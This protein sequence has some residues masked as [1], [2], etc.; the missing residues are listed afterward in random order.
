MI[1][2]LRVFV[3][4]TLGLV[5]AQYFNFL[6]INGILNYLWA[7]LIVMAAVFVIRGFHF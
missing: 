3:G 4:T 7:T 5:I 1:K 2:V 6:D